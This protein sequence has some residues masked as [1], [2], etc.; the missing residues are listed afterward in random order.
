LQ[1]MIYNRLVPWSLLSAYDK[2]DSHKLLNHTILYSH[3]ITLT[4]ITR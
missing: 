3:L 1:Q 2:M 4:Y